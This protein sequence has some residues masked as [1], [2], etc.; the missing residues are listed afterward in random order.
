M[1]CGVRTLLIAC[2]LLAWLTPVQAAFA[3]GALRRS[4]PSKGEVRRTVPR[5]LRL[6]FTERV[7]LAVTRVR[8]ELRCEAL[9]AKSP[10]MLA[11]DQ[12]DGYILA[13]VEEPGWIPALAPA[14]AELLR[15]ALTGF[16]KLAA[17][18]IE[19]L[20]FAL[21]YGEVLEFLTRN[22]IAPA[23]GS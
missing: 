11:F 19:G 3:H 22:G 16:Y 10:A 13:S 4:S 23:S 18:D 1:C 2:A 12:R 21:H 20:N 7:E 14:Q 9:D 15:V 5:E 6:T 17:V 8:I